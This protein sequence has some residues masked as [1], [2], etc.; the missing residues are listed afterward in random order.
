MPKPKK[1][2]KGLTPW[3]QSVL[4]A[5]REL[6]GSASHYAVAEKTGL[7]WT[8]AKRVM[9]RMGRNQV[10]EVEE[11]SG[12]AYCGGGGSSLVGRLPRF[13]RPASPNQP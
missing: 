5:V 9:R 8:S 11:T 1:G 7:T 13:K 12:P 4:E 10:L 3:E 6:G 2:G